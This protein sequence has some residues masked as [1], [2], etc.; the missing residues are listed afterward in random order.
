[1]RTVIAALFVETNGVYFGL[2]GVD[3][4]DVT[5]DARNYAGPHPV[6]AHP[7]CQLWVNFAALNY[8]R[9][10][11]E[12]NRPGNDGGCFEH[13]LRCVREFGGVL[14]HPAFSTA[15]SAFG[16]RTP[17]LPTSTDTPTGFGWALHRSE[18]HGM[19]SWSA[20]VYQ[21][22]YG[23]KARKR[24]WLYFVGHERPP[25]LDWSR[26]PGTHQ[27]GW[28]D[29]IK[30]TLSKKEASRTPVAFRDALINLARHSRGVVT[31]VA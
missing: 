16:L 18:G 21:S 10:G 22:A 28:F 17:S 14:E 8:K 7:P 25:E 5:R 24:T 26:N 12:H 30:P 20:E 15:W 27:V 19:C 13:A 4:W 1:V 2:E 23:H 11:G 9:Y 31:E 6:V 29:R 3:P